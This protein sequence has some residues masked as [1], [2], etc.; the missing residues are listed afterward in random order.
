M[1]SGR[2]IVVTGANGGLG[3]VAVAA[4][5]GAGARLLLVGRDESRLAELASEHSGA[6]ESVHA[7]DLLDSA[8]VLS[9]AASAGPDVDAVWHL[10]GGWRGG[11]RLP[12]Q[13]LGDWD[14]LHDQLVRTTV[15]VASCFADQLAARSAGRFAIVSSPLA[16]T[17]TSSNAAYSS[18]K[19]AA[20]AVVLALADHFR[21][22][23][24]TANIVV[25]PAILT[26]P[27]RAADPAGEVGRAVAAEDIG[28]ALVYLT[29]DEAAKMN[30]QRIRL[31]TGGP[32]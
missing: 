25:V 23:S 1:L 32:S 8:A 20:E 19:A 29:S 21:G 9:L 4:A 15:H 10:V 28:A 22:T 30:G 17:P 7:V 31:Y 13:S 14:W 18:A 16:L 27:M 2:K 5:A 11:P 6:V 3:P 26:P 12:D 24:A